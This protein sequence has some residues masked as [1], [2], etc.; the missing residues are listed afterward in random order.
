VPAGWH[1]ARQPGTSSA[2]GDVLWEQVLSWE[3]EISEKEC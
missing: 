3:I 1:A 2:R